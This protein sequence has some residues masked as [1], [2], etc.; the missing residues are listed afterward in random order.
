MTAQLHPGKLVTLRGREWVVLPSDDID[1]PPIGKPLGVSDDE[2]TGIYLPLD[3]YSD[4]PVDA[5]FLQPTKKTSA[6]YQRPD[7]FTTPRALH[8]GMA[9]DHSDL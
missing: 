5:C 6:I 4:R 9:P 1:D 7:F 8:F 2:I 3:I